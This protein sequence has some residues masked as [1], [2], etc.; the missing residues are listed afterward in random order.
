MPHK[1]KQFLD[2]IAGEKAPGPAPTF[3]VLHIL[4]ALEIAAEKCVGRG[5]LAVELGVGHGAV[6]TIISR[7]R[8]AGLVTT[9]KTGCSITAKG[10]KFWSEYKKIFPKKVEIEADKLTTARY[11]FAVLAKD[12]GGKVKSGMDQR[13]AAVKTGAK[14]A[15]TILFRNGRLV[16]PSVTEDFAKDFPETAE[17]I[18][19][20]LKPEENDVVV[21]SGADT[22][23][24][25]GYATTAATLTF[26]DDC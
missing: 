14:G 16:I 19:K 5:K 7:L 25:A 12:C 18:L 26:L 13:D 6:R 2:K 3:S 8:E 10:L 17:Q 23:K 1:L 11:N 20:L 22:L 15:V 24:L 21:I 4:R 9:S